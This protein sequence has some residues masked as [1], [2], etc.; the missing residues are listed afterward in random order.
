MAI[1]DDGGINTNELAS[2][3]NT[4]W[5]KKAVP[6]IRKQHGVTYAML[7]KPQYGQANKG[8][9]QF[10]NMR[11]AGGKKIEVRLRGAL[12]SPAVVARS[13]QLDALTMT[14]DDDALGG[15]Q[16]GMPMVPYVHPIP[17]SEFDR[18]RGN[19]AKT[20]DYL[21]EQF[22]G[23]VLGYENTLATALNN[24][25]AV[26]TNNPA[27]DV[28]GSYIFGIMGID[29]AWSTN[30]DTYGDLNRQDSGNADYR[31]QFQGSVAALSLAKIM[32]SKLDARK[33]G[34]MVDAGFAAKGVW[35]KLNSL[36]ENQAV[37][38]WSEEWNQFGGDYLKY[39]GTVYA[40]D[41]DTPSGYLTGLTSNT[42]RL[43]TL[44]D[45]KL[46]SGNLVERTDLKGIPYALPCNWWIQCICKHPA[47]NF[48]MSGITVD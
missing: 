28:I 22:E 43:Y 16:F 36:L 24:T 11:F 5:D 21:D 42:W 13:A 25:G 15:S 47:Q 8:L 44:K 29:G 4:L 26:A 23:I 1:W 35:L 41:P 45:M 27:E 18:F 3:F 7:G 32:S 9:P 39:A 2:V 48:V 38:T 30:P 33:Y 19:E 37:V 10:S 17:R 46:T 34:G 40:F 6:M 14:W 12:P 31:G 20:Y